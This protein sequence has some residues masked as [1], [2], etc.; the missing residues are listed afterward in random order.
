MKTKQIAGINNPNIF[1]LIDDNTIIAEFDTPDRYGRLSLEQWGCNPEQKK[2]VLY[3]FDFVAPF[4]F[5]NVWDAD[6]SEGW[7][8]VKNSFHYA[9]SA[10]NRY[11]PDADAIPTF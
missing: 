8:S 5:S 4:E 3:V 10:Y 9:A 1:E 6:L 2:Y 11:C 7:K